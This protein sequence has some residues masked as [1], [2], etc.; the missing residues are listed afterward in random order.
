LRK[1]VARIALGE[2]ASARAK[3]NVFLMRDGR[4]DVL[5]GEELTKYRREEKEL[6]E[7]LDDVKELKGQ[8]ASPGF[9]K[10]KIRVLLSPEEVHLLEKGEILVAR[11]TTPSFLPAMEKSAALVSEQGG[12]LC[13]TAIVGREL[14][15]PTIVG[16]KNAIKLLKTGDLVEVDAGKGVVKI[17][18]GKRK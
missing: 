9:A 10:G 14:K 5:V 8:C 15:I 6:V 3:D 17:L 11:A 4:V 12:L 16:V 2:V 1:N 18:G 7:K 13:H